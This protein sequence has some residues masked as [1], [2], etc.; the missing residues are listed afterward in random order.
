M[1]FPCSSKAPPQE[2][3]SSKLASVLYAPFWYQAI[4]PIVSVIVFPPFPGYQRI[5]IFV[6]IETSVSPK[7]TGAT[8]TGRSPWISN[9]AKSFFMSYLINLS[10]E[11]HSAGSSGLTV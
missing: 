10:V 9:N 6:P 4:F 7:E 3:P 5:L 2:F 8:S 11:K 1:K